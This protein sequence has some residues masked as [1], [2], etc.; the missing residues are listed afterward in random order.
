M[1][2]PV[3]FEMSLSLNSPVVSLQLYLNDL[4]KRSFE[5]LQVLV[6]SPWILG[7]DEET[8]IKASCDESTKI[9]IISMKCVFSL[10]TATHFPH[11][12]FVIAHEKAH[13]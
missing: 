13:G 1:I 6:N 8:F 12:A 5:M 11:V 4:N 7:R 3:Y 10:A 2:F 9:E